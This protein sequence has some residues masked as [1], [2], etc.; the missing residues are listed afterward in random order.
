MLHYKAVTTETL[1]LLKK[2]LR[3]KGLNKMRLVGGTSLALQI[4]HRKSIDLDLFG[5]L[6]MEIFDLILEIKKIASIQQIKNTPNIHIYLIDGVKVDIVNYSYPWIDEL[7]ST[8]GLRLA[9]LKDIAAMK[10]GAVTGRG[11]RKDFVD[12]YYLLQHFSVQEMMKFYLEKYSDGSE[13]LAIKSL[14]Y[15]EDAEQE[16][17][18]DMFEDVDWKH[19]KKDIVNACNKY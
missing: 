4:G 19:I 13:F 1:E 8:D 17:M 5:E 3:V 10:I 16:P 14:M 2:L 6:N 15:F 11:S 9:G 12:I 7:I 18:P